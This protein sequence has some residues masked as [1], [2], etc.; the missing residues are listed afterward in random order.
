M[1]S[2]TLMTG[3]LVCFAMRSAVR[4]RVP[5]SIVGMPESGTRWTL[6][7]RMFSQALSM[8]MAPSILAT[9]DRCWAVSLAFSWKP[10]DLSTSI[11]LS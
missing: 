6:A 5:V 8:R 9:S 3:M 10:P 2:D 11:C 7:H 1:D 4:C